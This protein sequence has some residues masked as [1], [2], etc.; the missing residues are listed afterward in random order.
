MQY[1]IRMS[2]A[3]LVLWGDIYELKALWTFIH[4]VMDES[5]LLEIEDP[6]LSG[7]ASEVRH[8]FDGMRHKNT[9]KWYG[10]D[11]TPIYGFDCIWPNI[12]IQMGLLRAG[13]AFMSTVSRN[14]QAVMYHLEHTVLECLDVMQPGASENL[15]KTALMAAQFGGE[16]INEIIF[17]RTCYFL[18]LEPAQRKNELGAVLDTLTG[19]GFF[20][21]PI[22]PEV[23]EPYELGEEYPPY[24]W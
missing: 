1:V 12:L 23:F 20:R 22:K 8:A 7:L 17:S 21:N 18:T 3:G 6:L 14:D 13:L 15:Y 9:R 4:R 10:D 2:N 5:A 19:M 24:N 11:P 16:R